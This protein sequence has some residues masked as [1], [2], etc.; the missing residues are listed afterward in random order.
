MKA[1][2]SRLSARYLAVLR[3]YLQP[4]APT[5]LLL[6]AGLGRQAAAQGL[7]TLDLARIHEQALMTLVSPD[8]SARTRQRMIERAQRFFA[9]AIVPIEKTHG[10]AQ[11]A[12]ALVN[13]LSQ[14]LRR[15]TV[16][17][18]ASTRHLE[19]SIAQ[20]KAAEAA[21]KKSREQRIRLLQES[22]RLQ[23]RLQYQTREILSAQ[24]EE[25]QKSSHQLHDEIAQTLV[26]INLRL[27]T[28]KTS[29]KANTENL[30]KEIA[31]TQR[32]VQQSVKTMY[33]LAHEL[34]VDHEK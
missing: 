23:N 31:E 21:L 6:A 14:T 10:A 7:E 16:E 3:Q 2:V 33:R 12:A 5:R 15:R 18:T 9:E 11:Q 26:A 4:G 1:K 30:Q 17:S 25:R 22:S 19:Q 29:A 32:L 28:L 8:G 24:E 13:Q 27:L 34:G 20:R